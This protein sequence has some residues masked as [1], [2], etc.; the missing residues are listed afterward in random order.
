MPKVKKEIVVMAESNFTK[1]LTNLSKQEKDN[2]L[3]ALSKIK[4]TQKLY[5]LSILDVAKAAGTE[6]TEGKNLEAFLSGFDSAIGIDIKKEDQVKNEISIQPDRQLSQW[7]VARDTPNTPYMVRVSLFRPFLSPITAISAIITAAKA[8]QSSPSIWV[9]SIAISA[10]LLAAFGESLQSLDDNAKQSLMALARLK[11]QGT[12]PV[13]TSQVADENA[14]LAS[15][16]SRFSSLSVSETEKA[17]TKLRS[18]KIVESRGHHPGAVSSANAPAR[19]EL[20]EKVI[21]L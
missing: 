20:R 9:L 14:Q 5:K 12:S 17:L 10:A 21:Y 2:A 18:Y 6:A 8:V 7:I 3:R 15:I 11:E 19:W 16:D 4:E 13:T 1:N